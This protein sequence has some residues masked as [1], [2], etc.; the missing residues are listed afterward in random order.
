MC[1]FQR[2]ADHISET[3]KDTTKIS[4][5]GLGV[6]PFRWN[7]NHPAQPSTSVPDGQLLASFWRRLPTASAFGQQLSINFHQL[8][9]PRHRLSTYGRRAFSVAGPTVWNSLP[10][11]LRDPECSG[12]IF[13]LSLSKKRFCFHSTSVFSALEV[14][15]TMRYINLHLTFD[16]WHR[17]WMILQL[18]DNQ[19][20]RL[21]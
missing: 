16:I 15:T 3:V 10:D 8:S 20:G 17:P 21:S 7:N 6:R 14:L 19:Y 12:N 9:V 2:K 18:T 4:L 5:I 1:V 11:D 13:R